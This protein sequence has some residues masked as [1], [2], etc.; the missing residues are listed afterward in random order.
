MARKKSSVRREKKQMADNIRKRV[1]SAQKALVDTSEEVTSSKEMATAVSSVA[2]SI[3]ALSEGQEKLFNELIEELSKI[4]ETLEQSEKKSE[5]VLE[6]L[7]DAILEMET[8]LE[9]TTDPAERAKLEQGITTLRGQADVAMGGTSRAQALR[10]PGDVVSKFL[11]VDPRERKEAGGGVSGFLKAFVGQ[12]KDSGIRGDSKKFFGI[13]PQRTVDDMLAAKRGSA[14]IAGTLEAAKTEKE[15]E[16]KAA[17][18]ARLKDVPEHMRVKSDET[19]RYRVAKSGNRLDEFLPSGE[20]NPRF[21]PASGMMGKQLVDEGSGFTYEAGK[22]VQTGMVPGG[23]GVSVA[24]KG[25]QAGMVPGGAGASVVASLAGGGTDAPSDTFKED[26][27]NKLDDM[28]EQLEDVETAADSKGLLGNIASVLGG[29]GGTLLTGIKGA[30]SGITSM[31]RGGG[32]VDLPPGA[33][34]GAAPVTKAGGR[35]ARFGRGAMKLAKGAG[36][37]L[38]KVA[39]PLAVGMAAYDAYKGFTADSDAPLSERLKNAGSSAVSGLTFGLAGSSP[40]EIAA[41]K[42]EEEAGAA[43]AAATGDF[44]PTGASAMTAGAAGVQ[45]VRPTSRAATSTALETSA[46]VMTAAAPVINNIDNSSK[47]NAPQAAGATSGAS[48][49]LR[50]TNNSFMRFQ[51]RRMARVF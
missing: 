50:D 49:S 2:V 29:L 20:L 47:V 43:P 5:K 25:V 7:L 21:Q 11:G 44:A 12:D 16:R 9:K 8:Q 32:G 28:E 6:K 22:G 41:R 35:M 1:I 27:L 42:A 30:F 26:L 33:G 45:S 34:P 31:F 19:G 23:A 48:V 38:G 4:P 3:E 14:D 39:A 17:V 10:T 36:R 37:V 18:A 46:P 24:D 15:N 13:Q 40:E 51:D